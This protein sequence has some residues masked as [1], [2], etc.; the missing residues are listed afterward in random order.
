MGRNRHNNNDSRR[1]HT[2]LNNAQED[3]IAA[4]II[5]SNSR[6][7]KLASFHCQQTLE[8]ALKG[9]ILFK[10]NRLVDGHNLLWL[11]K[12]A[13]KIDKDFTEFLD[14]CALLN[15]CYIETRYPSDLFFEVTEQ[16]ANSFFLSA[17]AVFNEICNKIYVEYTNPV[18]DV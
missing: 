7:Y 5:V 6:C 13:M 10:E 2:W 4:E 12:Q 11:C 1:F 14:E 18:A 3:I 15:H 17:K 16:Q 9:F 8:K